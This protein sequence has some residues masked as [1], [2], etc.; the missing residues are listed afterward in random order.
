[1]DD[2]LKRRV[3]KYSKPLSNGCI[4]WTGSTV[5][6]GY[7]VVAFKDELYSVRR[8]VLSWHAGP[9]SPRKVVLS[10]C[11]NRLCVNPAHLRAGSHTEAYVASGSADRIVQRGTK[12]GQ[13][14]LNPEAVRSIR[15][16]RAQGVSSGLLAAMLGVSTAAILKVEKRETWSHVE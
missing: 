14:K 9:I 13:A 2:Y 15:R 11:R 16:M 3:D 4:E 8:L 5:T 7:P 10:S 6:R 1:M 12:N